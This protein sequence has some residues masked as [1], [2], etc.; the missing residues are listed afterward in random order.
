MSAISELTISRS[1]LLPP[2]TAGLL[3]QPRICQ[4]IE[5]GL[6]C[7]LTLISGMA[8]YGKTAALADF[9][10]HSP[11]PV[12][13][14]TADERDSDLDIFIE[15]LVSAIGECFP[16]FG[17]RTREAWLPGPAIS[18]AISTPRTI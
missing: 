13:W 2:S 9:A 15:C 14:Y 5:R 1:K 10:R 6:E 17:E 12:C 18:L 11:V 16:G 7:K 3:H 8:G 4:T